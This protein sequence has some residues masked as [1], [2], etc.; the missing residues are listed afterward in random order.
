MSHREK[1][2]GN[3]HKKEKKTKRRAMRGRQNDIPDAISASRELEH[4]STSWRDQFG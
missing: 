3:K 1:C 2:H 4:P